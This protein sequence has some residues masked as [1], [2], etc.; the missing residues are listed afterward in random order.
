MVRLRGHHLVCLNFF[1]GEGLG[2]E[3][4]DN[5][6]RLLERLT[7]GEPVA[8]ADG[9]DEVCR[10]CPHRQEDLCGWD[11]AAVLRLDR[12]ALAALGTAAGGAAAWTELTARVRSLPGAWWEEFC[13]GCDWVCSRPRG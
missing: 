13:A 1:S 3:F 10:R 12:L 4:R 11:E 9:A 5:Y 6:R 2:D 8:V 7:G